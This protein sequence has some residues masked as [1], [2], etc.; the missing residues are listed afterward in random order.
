MKIQ[1]CEIIIEL[2]DILKNSEL[3]RE[4]AKTIVFDDVLLECFTKVL[5]HGNVDWEDGSTPWQKIFNGKGDVFERIRLELVSLAESSTKKLVQDLIVERDR[6]YNETEE[7]KLKS[8]DWQKKY[9]DLRFTIMGP[10]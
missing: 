4:I 3:V 2:S 8:F 6:L 7:W 9:N 5:I 1:N 10:L